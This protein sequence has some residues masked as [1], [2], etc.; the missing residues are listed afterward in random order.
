[1]TFTEFGRLVPEARGMGR[2]AHYRP[3][4]S[5]EP[6][7]TSKTETFRGETFLADRRLRSGSKFTER[8][9]VN[10]PTEMPNEASGSGNRVSDKL[11]WTLIASVDISGARD[12][13]RSTP[14][15][16]GYF[17]SAESM[18]PAALERRREQ[19][20]QAAQEAW[21]QSQRG[22]KAPNSH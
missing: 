5:E 15:R 21:D 4:P 2:T 12:V 7:E 1:M 6:I 11:E 17:S 8:V 9:R 22:G 13:T 16:I 20:R 10:V 18:S 3:V 14:I 19:A